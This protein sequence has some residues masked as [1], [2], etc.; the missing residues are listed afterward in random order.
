LRETPHGVYFGDLFG[1]P[2]FAH[3]TL[4]AAAPMLAFLVFIAGS[5]GDL[6]DRLLVLVFLLFSVLAH[7]LA[8]AFAGRAL[9]V[10]VKHI[11]LA[12][13]GGYAEFWMRPARRWQEITI[14]LA[15]PL[16]NLAIGGGALLL[17]RLLF[18]DA[19]QGWM[20]GGYLVIPAASEK[21]L[22]ENAVRTLGWVNVGLGLF[23]LLPGLPLDGGHVLRSVLSVFTSLRRAHAV[24]A[25]AGF[26]V[27]LGAIAYAVHVE[28]L[29]MVLIGVTV[30]ASGWHD[31]HSA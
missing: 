3:R 28:S 29:W 18:P 4:L 1:F 10:P 23:N 8:H 27:G 9:G 16:T 25:F 17:A 13:F 21:T 30:M 31:L 24:A 11:A 14:A 7:E 5:S 12:W 19:E 26:L 6:I 20:E 22:L 2:L 15:G